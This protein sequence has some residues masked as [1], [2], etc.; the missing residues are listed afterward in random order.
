[1]VVNFMAHGISRG[2]HKLARIPTLINK[3]N[4]T[5]LYKKSPVTTALQI[6]G[7]FENKSVKFYIDSYCS[8]IIQTLIKYKR[9]FSIFFYGVYNFNLR[10]YN[11]NL[12]I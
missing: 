12:R 4:H 5:K 9:F 8:F 11:F 7:L 3:K 10:I 6:N 1:M 2:T